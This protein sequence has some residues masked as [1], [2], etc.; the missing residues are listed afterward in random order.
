MA[1]NPNKCKHIR[2]TNKWKIVQS[3]YK[4]HGQVLKETTKAKYLGVTTDS[5]MTWNSHVDVVTKRA[6]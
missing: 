4:I 6:N 1:F 2:V 5:K 3:S